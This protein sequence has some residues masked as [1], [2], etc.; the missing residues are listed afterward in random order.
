M[1]KD[2]HTPADFLLI[3]EDV[4]LSLKEGGKAVATTPHEAAWERLAISLCFF[5]AFNAALNELKKDE[6]FVMEYHELIKHGNKNIFRFVI[7]KALQKFK[8]DDLLELYELWLNAFFRLPPDYNVDLKDVE[9]A[10]KIAGNCLRA[11][12]FI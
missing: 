5:A 2:D 6:G 11:M 8:L 10:V 12:Q 7:D 3:A 4:Y 9:K 1:Q